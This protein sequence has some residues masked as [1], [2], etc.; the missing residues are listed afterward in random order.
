MR[1]LVTGAAGMLGQDVT[2]AA[3]RAGH[4]VLPLSRG[5]L[6]IT[7]STAVRHTVLEH[8]PEAVINCA[9]WTDVDG[10]EAAEDAATAVN[11][12]AAGYVA[13]AAADAGALVVHVSSDY[14]FDGTATSPYMESAEV[15]PLSAYGR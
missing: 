3:T 4:D 12:T 6:D 7:D 1:L 15:N 2:A 11:G 8:G 13:R 14:V 10:A 9:A 5:E